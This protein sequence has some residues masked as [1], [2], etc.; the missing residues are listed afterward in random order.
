MRRDTDAT[1]TCGI[2]LPERCLLVTVPDGASRL[3]AS[4]LDY[5]RSM[6]DSG[7]MRRDIDEAVFN[8]GGVRS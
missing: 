6:P 8:F 3:R 5:G 1:P 2:L 7:E 4:A